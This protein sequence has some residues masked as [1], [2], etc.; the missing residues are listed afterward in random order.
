[1]IW[2]ADELAN[3]LRPFRGQRLIG[4]LDDGETVEVVFSQQ[5]GRPNLLSL[6]ENGAVTLGGVEH[7]D[8]YVRGIDP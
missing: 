1:M 7:P 3:A 4:V 5:S 2:T 8:L 6:H